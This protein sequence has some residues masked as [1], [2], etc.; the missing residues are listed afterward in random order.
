MR[1][2]RRRA[3]YTWFPNLGSAAV[4]E[5]TEPYQQLFF[6]MDLPPNGG[7]VTVVNPVTIDTPLEGTDITADD[8]LVEVIG[9]EYVIERIVGKLFLSCQAAADDPPATIFPKTVLIGAGFAVARAN[10][11]N[12][13]GGLNT[14]IGS[15]TLTERNDNYG[16]LSLDTIREPWMWRRTWILSTGRAPPQAGPGIGTPFAPILDTT[17]GAS[18]FPP[19]TNLLH[20]SALDGPHLD[21]KSVRRVRQDER[22]WFCVSARTLDNEFVAFAQLPNTVGANIVAGILDYRVLGALRKAKA[23]SNF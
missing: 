14:P 19:T 13:G 6:T 20:G 15:A 2:R 10:D 7:L 3:K 5:L 12:S 1:R 22:L 23:R 4:N 16:P 9:N 8:Q 17:S 11:T 21:V 18:S